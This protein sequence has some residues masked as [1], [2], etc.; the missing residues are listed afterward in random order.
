MVVY[1]LS[2]ILAMVSFIPIWIIRKSKAPSFGHL[3][4]WILSFLIFTLCCYFFLLIVYG[5]IYGVFYFLLGIKISEE[6]E[7]MGSYVL[8]T[9]SFL[10]GFIIT[11]SL[12]KKFT[13]KINGIN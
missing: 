13:V 7:Y 9:I 2:I 8:W 12:S 10:L 3:F 1:V 4:D 11:R 5:M 6:L